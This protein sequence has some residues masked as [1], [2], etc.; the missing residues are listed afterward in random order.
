MKI[1]HNINS[2]D[3]ALCWELPTEPAIAGA[4]KPVIWENSFAWMT[5]DWVRVTTCTNPVEFEVRQWDRPRGV[6]TDVMIAELRLALED[7]KDLHLRALYRAHK[8]E[9]KAER[10][11][12]LR[13]QTAAK[14][15]QVRGW[16]LHA[17]QTDRVVDDA[18]DYREALAEFEAEK[19]R[20]YDK[21]DEKLQTAYAG[22]RKHE[23]ED[24]MAYLTARIGSGPWTESVEHLM[25]VGVAARLPENKP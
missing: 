16:W 6:A 13:E 1:I 24:L 25:H 5:P 9:D 20:W 14:L 19:S 12:M 3:G 18:D 23:R 8:A 17:S 21:R 10:E 15:E 22:G 4:S 11:K 7:A 2:E